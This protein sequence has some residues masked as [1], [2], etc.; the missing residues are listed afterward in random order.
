[1]QQETFALGDAAQ[2]FLQVSRLACKNQ[3]RIA[4]ELTLDNFLCR[5]RD[6]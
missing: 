6:L 5:D 1:L 4:R 2:R 3:R